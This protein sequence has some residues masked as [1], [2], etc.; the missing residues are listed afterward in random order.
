MGGRFQSFNI[1]QHHHS[2][3]PIHFQQASQRPTHHVIVTITILP[4]TIIT[5]CFPT[6]SQSPFVCTSS[7]FHCLTQHSS[8]AF[9]RSR[10]TPAGSTINQ[11]FS[12]Q[13]D[14]HFSRHSQLVHTIDELSSTLDI[15]PQQFTL[16]HRNIFARSP[17]TPTHARK[18]PLSSRTT[19]VGSNAHT[20]GV[21]HFVRS[22]TGRYK[23]AFIGNATG[24]TL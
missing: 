12:S 10:G 21:Q 24:Y 4:H 22:H 13:R 8:K 14:N 1:H 7:S 17:K 18:A 11:A 19:T 6:C 3:A 9:H 5:G 16:L 20:L 23:P 15:D 2:A